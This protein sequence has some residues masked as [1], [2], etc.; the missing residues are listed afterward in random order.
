M[1]RRM[2]DDG[3]TAT[4]QFLD[5]PKGSQLLYFHLG[6]HA[7]DD[8]FISNPKMVMRIIGSSEDELTVLY[9]KKFLLA[10]ESGVCVIKHWR[11]NNYLRKQIY[12]PT[13]YTREKQQLYIRVNGTYTFTEAD[14]V[15]VPD[16]HFTLEMLDKPASTIRRRNVDLGKVRLGKVRVDSSAS[17]TVVNFEPV[18]IKLANYLKDCIANNFAGWRPPNTLDKWAEDIGRLRR[19]DQRTEQEI[20]G[21]IRWAQNSEFWR[22]NILSGAKL[23]KQFNKLYIEIE[24]EHKSK[25]G[26]IAF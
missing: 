15:P 14:A 8:G 16:G 5:M 3:I 18:D 24:N 22:K 6:M 7:D 23:R 2:F 1:S 21:V 11:I 12:K 19:L 9:A 20:A 13:K 10:F 17:A 4:D 26:K 25:G